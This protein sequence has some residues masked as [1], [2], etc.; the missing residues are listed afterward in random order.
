MFGGYDDTI[1]PRFAFVTLFITLTFGFAAIFILHRKL[2]A[3]LRNLVRRGYQGQWPDLF[4]SSAADRSNHK[5]IYH[6]LTAQMMLPLAYNF[7]LG[8]W[9]V[10]ALGIVH[11]RTLQRTVFTV[12]F[13]RVIGLIGAW[14]SVP[15]RSL[16]VTHFSQ[17]VFSRSFR[18]WSTCTTFRRT[19]GP[20]DRSTND[21][22][23]F[24]YI[25]SLFAPPKRVLPS[26]SSEFTVS[27]SRLWPAFIFCS[28]CDFLYK[29]KIIT[30]GSKRA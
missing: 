20:A 25:K 9:F 18:R 11:S 10:D 24:R 23:I 7:G 12:S 30:R 26:S 17:R 22:K 4:Q 27:E 13:Y 3:C 19:G 8:L 2:F 5:M 28:Q 6:S 1:L 14:A 15:S 29:I 21:I 16:R